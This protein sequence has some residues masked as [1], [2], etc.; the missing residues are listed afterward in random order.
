MLNPPASPSDHSAVTAELS[1]ATATAVLEAIDP[2]I[3][4]LEHAILGDPAIGHVGLVTRLVT[5]EDFIRQA[6]QLHAAI[7]DR[8]RE[9]TARVHGRIDELDTSKAELEDL[10]ALTAEVH[11]LRQ[12]L[13]RIVYAIVGAILASGGGG[14]ALARFLGGA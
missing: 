3:E 12:R 10:K 2:R 6:G 14:Y 4:R 5:V 11:A 9:S 1:R 13:D 7:E 8:A